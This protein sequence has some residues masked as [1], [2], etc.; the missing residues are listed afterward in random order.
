MGST[1][2]SDTPDQLSTRMA[3]SDK[4]LE[5]LLLLNGLST[6]SNFTPGERYKIVTE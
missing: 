3:V 2:R 6:V 5:F 4:P 1:D